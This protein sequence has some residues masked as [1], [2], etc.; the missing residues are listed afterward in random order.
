MM[1]VSVSFLSEVNRLESVISDLERSSADYIH[2]DIMDGLFV[3]N[4]N[5]DINQYERIFSRGVKPLD[6]HLMVE[7]VKTYASLYS[8]LKPEFI[9]FHYEA[10]VDVSSMIDFIQFMG[11]KCGI[12]IKPDTSVSDLIPYLSKVDLVLVMSVL[13][14]MGGQSFIESSVSKIEEL[15]R[16]RTEN[17]YQYLIEVD[18]GIDSVSSEMCKS[19]D[20]LVS[21]SYIF[22]DSNYE[23]RIMMLKTVK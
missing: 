7:D 13:P 4:I 11:C 23:Q 16:I 1:K 6:I 17:N 15:V 10:G 12:S 18:G 19:A 22:K 5:G 21:G 3:P 9:T 2:L 8:R 20:I 14:G